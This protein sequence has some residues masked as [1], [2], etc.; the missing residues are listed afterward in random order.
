VDGEIAHPRA[1]RLGG[2]YSR[3]SI[4]W[5]DSLGCLRCG[6][7][8]HAHREEGEGDRRAG[9]SCELRAASVAHG[10]LPSKRAS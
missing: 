2:D 6:A 10:L 5:A 9:V 8:R 4:G 1:D 7:G 3:R